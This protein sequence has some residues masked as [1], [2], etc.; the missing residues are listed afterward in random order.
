MSR[1]ADED[2]EG[3][4]NETV[5]TAPRRAPVEICGVSDVYACFQHENERKPP[6][7]VDTRRHKEFVAGH[8]CGAFCVAMT[9]ACT[10]EDSST[11]GDT[12]DHHDIKRKRDR[13]NALRGKWCANT[14]M[15]RDLFIY[16]AAPMTPE[17]EVVAYLQRDEHTL[18]RRICLLDSNY[19]AFAAKYPG[20]CTTQSRPRA[21]RR[22]P[23]EVIA[24]ELYLGDWQHASDDEALDHLNVGA[25][26]TIHQ[27]PHDLRVPRRRKHLCITQDDTDSDGILAH[28][29]PAVAFIREA[30][31]RGV[32]TLV[33]CGAGISRSASLVVGFL[34]TQRRWSLAR[35]L[36]AC[37]KARPQARPNAGFIKALTT[38]QAQ[39]SITPE[40]PKDFNVAWAAGGA[41][42]GAA[43]G[44]MGSSDAP[45]NTAA[46]PSNS[47][48]IGGLGGGGGVA[49]WEG[50]AEDG[51]RENGAAVVCIYM[52]VCVC[53]YTYIHIHTFT[54]THIHACMH[55]YIHTYIHTMYI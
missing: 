53:L 48:R 40:E 37:V 1:W 51:Q 30:S 21:P 14:W 32:A 35:A 52:C 7:V 23:A 3:E 24:G 45:L 38:L 55:T 25:V 49:E 13:L 16:G 2:A 4:L 39:L 9:Q 19:A 5:T 43:G 15:G 6:L 42:S 44:V 8:V 17:H 26:L 34:M 31:A 11:R 54:H 22:Y 18:P 36:A 20:L 28:I 12:N 27:R 50:A 41:D 29:E 10:L 47:D 46:G 33:H